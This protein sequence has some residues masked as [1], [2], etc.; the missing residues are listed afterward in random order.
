MRTLNLSIIMM[1]ISLATLAL[2]VMTHAVAADSISITTDQPVHALGESVA[3]TVSYMGGVHGDVDLS[4]VDSSGGVMNQWSWN[5]ASSEPFQ[6]TVSYA[7]P[8]PG[9]YTV[10]V[11]H[12]PHHMEP[13]A[14][15]SAQVAFWSARIVNLEYSDTVDAGK[16][17]NV[18]ATVSYYFTFPA[19][20]K[21]ELW[22][23]SEGKMLGALT[24]TLNGQ[25]T[26]TMT[27]SNVQFTSVQRQ[28]ITARVYYQTPTGGWSHDATGWNYSG[29]VAVAP[30]FATT[31]AIMLLLS[32]ASL[33]IIRE[34]TGRTRKK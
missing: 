32:L 16:P 9:T 18:D 21:I 30:E 3:L 22:S 20:V 2:A 19:Q 25:R 26:E 5:H 1:T 7:P 27:L 24:E 6:Q 33:L 13:P 11:M 34:R 4:F 29:K 12:R 15:A 31:P 23:D 14:S 17:V 10:D 28:D 8:R